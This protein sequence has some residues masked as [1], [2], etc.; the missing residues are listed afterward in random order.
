MHVNLQFY[1]IQGSSAKEIRQ[2]LNRLSPV[3][4]EGKSYD[5]YT[6]WHVSWKYKLAISGSQCSLEQLQTRVEVE[7]TLPRLITQVSF[8][9]RKRWNDYHTALTKHENAHKQ[10]AIDAALQ[11]KRLLSK[12]PPE[13][14]CQTLSRKANSL[15]KSIIQDHVQQEKEF[16]ISTDHGALQGARFP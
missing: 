2:S 16:D 10:F 13:K 6:R 12:L 15:G 5:A 14:S 11:I 8:D 9:L 3:K 4:V 7:Q 1:D